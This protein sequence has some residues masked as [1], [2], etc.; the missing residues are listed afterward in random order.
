MSGLPMKELLRDVNIA[1][2][3]KPKKV[4]NNTIRYE[5]ADGSTCWRLHKTDVVTVKY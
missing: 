2:D 1:P 4:A 3:T 5:A